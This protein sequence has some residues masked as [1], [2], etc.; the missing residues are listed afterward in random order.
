M[1]D[2]LGTGG[3][4][5]GLLLATVVPTALGQAVALTVLY[6]LSAAV[7]ALQHVDQRM[8]REGLG[9]RARARGGAA[10]LT[11]AAPGARC[12]PADRR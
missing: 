6:A 1:V 11:G 4:G 12:C 10:P 3:D 9:P 5:T 8:R 2:A 7:T